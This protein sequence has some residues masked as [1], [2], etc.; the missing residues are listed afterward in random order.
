LVS[1]LQRDVSAPPP[2]SFNGREKKDLGAPDGPAKG[3][4]EGL[5]PSGCQ[6]DVLDKE[7]EM[8]GMSP[9]IIIGGAAVGTGVVAQKT[10]TALLPFTGVAVG[11]YIALAVGLVIL[12]LVLRTI[13]NKKQV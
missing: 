7:L 6:A 1:V 8:S 12:G 5:A 10:A 3:E 11:I 2:E 4:P 13:G 9:G